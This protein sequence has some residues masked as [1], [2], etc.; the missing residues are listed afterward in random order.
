MNQEQTKD[1]AA[2]AARAGRSYGTIDPCGTADH[3]RCF[4]VI[5]FLWVISKITGIILLLVLSIFF[6]YLVSPL[7]EFCGDQ[8]LSAAGQ[9]RSLSR[10]IAFLTYHPGSDSACDPYGRANSSNQFPEFATQAKE[11]LAIRSATSSSR[12]IDTHVSAC[13]LRLLKP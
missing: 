2:T 7:V 10:A 4:R 3:L 9:S 6:A 13:R 8:E 5:G 1:T 11:L 12:L